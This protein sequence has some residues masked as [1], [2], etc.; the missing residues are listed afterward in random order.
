MVFH[1]ESFPWKVNFSSKLFTLLVNSSLVIEHIRSGRL[2]KLL[3]YSS[4]SPYSL[5]LVAPA[6]QFSWKK[7]KLFEDWLV[8]KLIESFSD[9]NR[10]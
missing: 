8:P 2:V 3:N 10:Y 7:V 5:Y 4:K 6:Q 9:L 1:T